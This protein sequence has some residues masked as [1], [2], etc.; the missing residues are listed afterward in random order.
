MLK[1]ARW[2][3]RVTR[4]PNIAFYENGE[5]DCDANEESDTVIRRILLDQ[6]LASMSWTNQD[7]VVFPL[8]G[9]PVEQG[10]ETQIEHKHVEEVAGSCSRYRC[11]H[12]SLVALVDHDLHEHDCNNSLG[13]HSQRRDSN[14]KDYGNGWSFSGDLLM[15]E[16]VET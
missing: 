10:K 9:H 2:L 11:S 4:N 8:L 6:N 3:Q 16:L 14:N 15:K 12:P 13:P 1:Q 5:F 7:T